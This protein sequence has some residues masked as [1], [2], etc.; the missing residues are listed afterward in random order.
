[1]S[2]D[3]SARYAEE[4]YVTISQALSDRELEMMREEMDRMIVSAPTSPGGAVDAA[5]N[6]VE[7]PE[8]FSFPEED[9]KKPILIRISRQLRRSSL[10]RIIYGSPKVLGLVESIYGPEFVPF[11]ES[12]IVKL[13]ADGARIPHHRDGKQH[14]EV[15]HRGLNLGIWAST[16]TDQRAPTAVSGPFRVSTGSATSTSTSSATH[17]ATSCLTAS[18]SRSPRATS[19]STTAP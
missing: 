13:P 5:G 4:G 3:L 1:M 18:P 2:T 9:D 10:M 12:I 14:Y 6:T 16:S 11:G 8:D 19:S 15:E 17:T 7:W